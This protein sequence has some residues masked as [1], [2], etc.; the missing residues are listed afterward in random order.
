MLN[1]MLALLAVI[2]ATACAATITYY[3]DSTSFLGATTPTQTIDF[4]GIASP[5]GSADFSSASGLTID[6]VN[7]TGPTVSDTAPNPPVDGFT[8]TVIDAASSP[9]LTDFGTGATLWGP[10]SFQTSTFG[11]TSGSLILSLPANTDSVG[12]NLSTIGIFS[13]VILAGSV[14]DD[15]DVSV[16]GGSPFVVHPIVKPGFAFAGFVSD[17]PISTIEISAAGSNT[18]RI[19]ADNVLL[20]SS[21]PVPEPAS[22]ISMA[23][24]A[25]GLA[26]Y[27][28][29]KRSSI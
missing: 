1:K 6:G 3:T 17:A 24:G 20:S 14:G 13:G 5:G 8:L 18:F 26:G 7:F 29:R 15:L 28:R 4:E 21:S 23:I 9:L 12:L 22:L 16:N 19:V 2:N 25:I 10:G 27:L 11:G